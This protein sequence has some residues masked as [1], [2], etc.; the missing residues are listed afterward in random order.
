MI[1]TASNYA[2]VDTRND[3]IFFKVDVR[4]TRQMSRT[5]KWGRNI[6]ILDADLPLAKN[7]G[8]T[9]TAVNH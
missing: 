7:Q 3:S 1:T 4:I 5:G 6:R 9:Y 2:W 8:M